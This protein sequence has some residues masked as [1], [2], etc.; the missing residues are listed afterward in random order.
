MDMVLKYQGKASRSVY[1][2]K[3]VSLI[4]WYFRGI[5][6]HEMQDMY[7]RDI[8]DEV[9][10]SIGKRL[11]VPCE[12]QLVEKWRPGQRRCFRLWAA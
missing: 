6:L 8:K 12:A 2:S 4:R 10:R 5:S 3:R 1:R 7:G 9:N 11:V